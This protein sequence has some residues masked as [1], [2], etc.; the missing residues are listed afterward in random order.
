MK[1]NLYK[2]YFPS[3]HFEKNLAKKLVVAYAFLVTFGYKCKLGVTN[4]N[5]GTIGDI[6][7][8][9]RGN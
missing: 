7:I 9:L 6:N 3:F 8:C 1:V 2:L 4:A 5:W